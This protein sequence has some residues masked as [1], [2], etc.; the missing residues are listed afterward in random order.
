[1]KTQIALSVFTALSASMCCITPALAIAAGTSSLATSFHWVDPF[2][3]YFVSAS[4]L[5]LGFAW[6]QT[7]K[8]KREDDCNCETPKKKFFFQSRTFLSGVTILSFLLIAFPTYSRFLFQHSGSQVVQEQNK[9]KKIELTVSGMTCT[10][11]ELHIESEVKKLPGVSFVKASYEKG[12]ATVEFDEQK[13]NADKIIEAIIGTGYKV[14]QGKKQLALQEQAGNCC[15][16]GTCKDH[17]GNLPKEINKNL[18]IVTSVSEI[19]K[20]FNQQTGKTKFVAILSSTCGWCLQGAESIQKT[21]IDKSRNKDIS[22]IIIW[23]NMLKTDDQNSAYKAASL[24]NE[25]NVT[26][27]FDSENKFGD[28]V[29]QRLNPQGKKAWDIYMFFDQDTQW[30]KD[31][32]RPFEYVHQLSSSVHP[33]VDKTKYFCGPDLTKRLDEIV[34]TL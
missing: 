3:P 29:A 24:F 20:A 27:F 2:R 26:Q 19:Q 18:K 4:V 15:A 33:W 17:A 22:V 7:I 31:F 1:M 13:I 23:T 9:N 6:F 28:V 21:V 30:R 16:N 12:S 10:S 8:T 14:E 5:V 25:P 11:C 34:I 32:P